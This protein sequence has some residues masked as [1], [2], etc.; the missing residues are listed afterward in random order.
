MN[1]LSGCLILY[2][3]IYLK[4]SLKAN[5]AKWRWKKKL[6][7][8]GKRDN[9]ERQYDYEYECEP[10]TNSTS[11][12]GTHNV[13]RM[14]PLITFALCSKWTSFA[15]WQSQLIAGSELGFGTQTLRQAADRAATHCPS[16]RWV[17]HQR[18]SSQR[19]TRLPFNAFWIR[20]VGQPSIK[21]LGIK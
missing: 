14:E 12:Q 9:K 21:E 18:Q 17:P 5:G 4:G 15:A 11:R 7:K 20:V 3:K 2:K 16:P 13:P 10:K 8:N 1:G 19:T 6:N